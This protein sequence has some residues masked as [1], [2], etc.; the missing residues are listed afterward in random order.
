MNGAINP[1]GGPTQAY[2]EWGTSSSLSPAQLT[3]AGNMGLGTGPVPLVATLTGLSNCATYYYRAVALPTSGGPAVRGSIVSTTTTGCAP[4]TGAIQ[5]T[6]A[7]SGSNQPAGPFS[8]RPQLEV[9]WGHPLRN[10]T[11]PGSGT[12]GGTIQDAGVHFQFLV[13]IQ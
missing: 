1:N 10:V 9:Y 12:A 3:T 7:V 8:V 13:A 11:I 2:F 4:T 5:V 6:S